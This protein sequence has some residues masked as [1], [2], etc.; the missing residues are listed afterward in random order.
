VRTGEKVVT[1]SVHHV[2]RA[3]ILPAGILRV[4][5]PAISSANK[6]LCSPGALTTQASVSSSWTARMRPGLTTLTADDWIVYKGQKHQVS[7]VE[8]FEFDSGWIITT[9]ES[10]G[11]APQQVFPIKADSLM[12]LSS[13]CS[14]CRR[15]IG[16][17]GYSLPWPITQ[18]SGHGAESARACRTPR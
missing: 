3:I 18:T 6:R 17:D 16:Q 12:C 8:S 13:E 11:E 4:R 15:R 1:T 10:V 14:D 9:K 2:R 7:K 5:M